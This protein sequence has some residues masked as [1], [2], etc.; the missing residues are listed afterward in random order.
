MGWRTLRVQ[1]A[2]P[3]VEIGTVGVLC[4]ARILPAKF[5]TY[6]ELVL[7]VRSGRR[8]L[9]WLKRVFPVSCHCSTLRPNGKVV[10]GALP[11]TSVTVFLELSVVR[12]TVENVPPKCGRIDL[13]GAPRHRARWCSPQ[14]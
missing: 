14:G 5:A 12:S 9:D 8:R 13:R 10:S 1:R 6:L 3:N 7:E 4:H 11:A 2:L